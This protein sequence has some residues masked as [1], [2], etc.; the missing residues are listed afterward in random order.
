MYMYFLSSPMCSF[1]FNCV[2]SFKFT[3][4]SLSLHACMINSQISL[5]LFEKS[6]P[7]TEITKNSWVE[8]LCSVDV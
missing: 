3:H 5:E 8:V 6:V 1:S 7:F 2:P 4:T